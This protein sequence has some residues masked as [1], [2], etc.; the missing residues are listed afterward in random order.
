[1]PGAYSID[2]RQRVIRS[3]ENG[4]GQSWIAREFGISLGTVKR[5]IKRY[6]ERGTV[7]PT[8]QKR[9]QPSIS[10]E[11]LVELQQEVDADP[12]ASIRNYIER[13]AAKHG[14]RVGHA[15][16][17]RALQRANRPR[18]KDTRRA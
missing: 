9:Q 11:R 4:R 15:T 3:W 14:Q 6:L 18:K 16:M 5:Y 1:M 12:D 2:L 8:V 10:Q 13:W 7:A 17:V